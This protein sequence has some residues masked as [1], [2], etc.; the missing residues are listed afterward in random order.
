MIAIHL[1][2]RGIWASFGERR[3]SGSALVERV[4]GALVAAGSAPRNARNAVAPLDFIDDE[5]LLVD[6]SPVPVVNAA[7]VV[8]GHA[9]RE[10]DV[11]R[12][13]IGMTLSHPSH[14]G[15]ARVA[16]LLHC[17][18]QVCRD[19]TA[20]PVALAAVRGAGFSV[21]A[22]PTGQQASI[23]VVLETALDD[24][25]VSCVSATGQ[26]CEL[27][28]VELVSVDDTDGDR[29]HRIAAAASTVVRSSRI[30]GVL[31]VGSGGDCDSVWPEAL[32][33]FF[34]VPPPRLVSAHDVLKGLEC[35]DGPVGR[36]ARMGRGA[37]PAD[38][39]SRTM[40]ERPRTPRRWSILAVGGVVVAV[41]I[42]ATAWLWSG[43]TPLEV[44]A[45]G[46]PST[47]SVAEVPTS[48]AAAESSVDPSPEPDTNPTPNSPAELSRAGLSFELPSGWRENPAGGILQEPRVRF[49]LVWEG[50]A[51][52]RIVVVRA[53]L[54]RSFDIGTVTSELGERVAHDAT[55]KF[56]DFDPTAA[57][58]NRTGIAYRE[59]PG[60]GSEVR[61]LVVVEDSVQ[62]SIGCQYLDG[63]WGELH[64][65][66]D[67][68]ITTLVIEP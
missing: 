4:D 16:R 40:S 19:T 51:S 55:G 7:A 8:L 9:A 28:G 39:I 38:W 30:D 42:G 63:Q 52:R 33:T 58:G 43:Q 32:N 36:T 68:I 3:W 66:C 44:Q 20:V 67:R 5:Y 45:T 23:W 21:P 15:S 11:S 49:E 35:V 56:T 59:H 41:L 48:A 1:G 31:I 14:W 13:E 62:V 26:R 24:V 6:L 57:A 10:V 53:D 60:D 34:Q 22:F 64:E 54:D 17:A 2:S 12:R 18:R 27:L 47:S 37:P 29:A 25:V 65:D 61:W 46:G 50:D